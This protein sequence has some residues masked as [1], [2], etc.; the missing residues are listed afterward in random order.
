MGLRFLVKSAGKEALQWGLAA[1]VY[2]GLAYGLKE[3]RGCHDWKNSA[4][5]GAIAGAAVALTGDTD[6]RHADH[7]VHFAITGAALSSAASLLS[8]II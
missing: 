5:A 6:T 4:I 2:S 7:I 3:I 1:G 8:G